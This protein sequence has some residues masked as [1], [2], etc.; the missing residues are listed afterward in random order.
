MTSNICR[1][2]V[3]SYTSL[4]SVRCL[5][6]ITQRSHHIGKATIYKIKK[7][8]TNAIW[9]VLHDAHLESPQEMGDLIAITNEFEK[10]ELST[11]NWGNRWKACSIKYPKLS[12]TQYFNDEG[13]LVLLRE[14]GP[15]A[16][17]RCFKMQLTAFFL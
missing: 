16:V 2:D 6:A 8:T 13:F 9:E 3:S 10:L 1:R 7:E 4:F 17:K 15:T 14:K 5:A 11:P 12:A